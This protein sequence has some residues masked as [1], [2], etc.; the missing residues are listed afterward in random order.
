M[1]THNFSTKICAVCNQEYTPKGS[2][3]KACNGCKDEYHRVKRAEYR[4]AKRDAVGAPRKGDMLS[5][6]DCGTQFEYTAGPQRKCKSC[7]YDAR[8]S[9]TRKWAK[10]NETKNKQYRQKAK[11]NYDFGG[12]RIKALERDNYTCQRCGTNEKLHIH[13]IDGRGTTTPRCERNN[14]LDNLQTLCCSCHTTVHMEQ[15][16][17]SS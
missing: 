1:K 13:H 14:A 16:R 2:S 5:C 10:E 7:R 3:Q 4:R 6:E 9:Y 8:V 15:N 11:D 17:H 12:N